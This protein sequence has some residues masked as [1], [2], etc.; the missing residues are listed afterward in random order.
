MDIKLKIKQKVRLKKMIHEYN[1]ADDF[2]NK[3]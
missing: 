2:K 3:L 1:L